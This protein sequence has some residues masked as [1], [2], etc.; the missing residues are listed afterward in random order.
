[1]VDAPG[2][3]GS[4]EFAALAIPDHGALLPTTTPAEMFNASRRVIS[5]MAMAPAGF[6]CPTK[7]AGALHQSN[8]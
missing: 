7:W 6:G 2:L 5:T 8:A 4:D 1:M 3:F